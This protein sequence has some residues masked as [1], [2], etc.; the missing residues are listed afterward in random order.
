MGTCDA[1]GGRTA[2]R[3]GRVLAATAAAALLLSACNGG[4]DPA[5]AAPDAAARLAAVLERADTLL[6]AGR[7]TEWLLSV[8]TA[9]NET[10]RETRLEAVTCAGTRCV[11]EDGAATT[12]RD[13]TGPFS[14]T[15][16]AEVGTSGRF[17]TA[18]VA[19]TVGDVTDGR[20]DGIMVA[21]SPTLTSWGFWGA[22]GFAALALGE[23]RLTAAVDGTPLDG[24]FALATA[25]ALGDASGTNPAGTGSATWAG[26]AEA[27]PTGA[28]ERLQGAAAVTITELSEPRPRVSVAIAVPGHAIGGWADAMPLTG[29]RFASGTAGSDYVAGS[30]HGPNHEEAWGVFDTADYLGAFGAKRQ[31]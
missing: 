28:F 31:P 9:G 18:M 8:R 14:G 10:I 19:E 2:L 20:G 22:H 24:T 11:G 23:G 4:D 12:L 6:A 17:D 16:G 29:G 13:L 26:I 15:A 25:Y 30:L 27:T 1:R 21:A 5:P 7:R 3:K